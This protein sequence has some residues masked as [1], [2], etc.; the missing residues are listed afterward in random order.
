MLCCIFQLESRIFKVENQRLA[1]CTN[2]VPRNGRPWLLDRVRHIAS[3]LMGLRMA[4]KIEGDDKSP[5]FGS[6]RGREGGVEGGC[7]TVRNAA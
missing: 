4:D 1:S 7:V 5:S 2:L 6:F 3:G